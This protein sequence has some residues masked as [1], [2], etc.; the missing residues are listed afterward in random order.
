MTHLP[1]VSSRSVI[2]AVSPHA[3]AEE[4]SVKPSVLFA[5]RYADDVGFVWNTI[6]RVRDL[7]AGCLQDGYACHLAYPRLTGQP[8][9]RPQ[10]LQPVELDCYDMSDANLAR[11]EAFVRQHRVDVIVYMSALPATLRLRRLRAMG[12]RTINT[13]NDSFDHRQRD[14]LYKALLKQVVRGWLR[15]QLHDIHI[16]NARSQGAYLLNHYKLPASRLRTVVNGIDCD[17]FSPS[18]AGAGE[19][20]PPPMARNRSWI[21]CVGQARAEKRVEWIIR[22]A[23]RLRR[24]L[25]GSDFGFVYV[26]AGPELPRWQELVDTLGVGDDFRFA[27]AQADVRP[28][29]R[30][31]AF[32]VH[33]AERESFGLAVVE[34]M[35]CGL[36]VVATAAA[37]P[38]ETIDHGV[39][40]TLVPLHD[41]EGFYQAIRSLLLDPERRAVQGLAARE[42]ALAHYSIQRQAAEFAAIVRSCA[43]PN[44]RRPPAGGP[45]LGSAS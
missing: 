19:P 27:G 41:E 36:P 37:G 29:Y 1:P 21:V 33:A 30:H 12:L 24:E 10:H 9:Y 43:A 16:S 13:E 22:A 14:P 8:A 3:P 11:I 6:A 17:R 34:A 28:F 40:G 42:R 44:D 5:M 2:C 18:A 20:P 45:R 26:G 38:S 25:P 7:V 15:L 23:A 31:A 4:R 35:A 32:M 39:T